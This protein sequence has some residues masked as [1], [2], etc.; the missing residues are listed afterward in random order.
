MNLALFNTQICEHRPNLLQFAL[1]FTRNEDDADDLVQDTLIKAIRYSGLYQEGTN[2]KGWLYTILRNTFMNNYRSSKRR[3]AV[4]ETCEEINPAQLIHG[5]SVNL[6]EDKFLK[7][8]IFKAIKLVPSEYVVPF[9]RYF[10]GYKYHEI[11]D[12]LNIPI[13]T[14]KTRIFMARKHLKSYLK[15]YMGNSP[16]IKTY[17]EVN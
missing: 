17:D 15:M 10:E 4:I 13:G 2:L 14:V 11:A 7:E 5:A 16:I 9:L 12:E 8:D 6:G 1:K 3:L